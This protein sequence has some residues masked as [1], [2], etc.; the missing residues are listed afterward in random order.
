M[1]SSN[2]TTG[3]NSPTESSAP[4]LFVHTTQVNKPDINADVKEG[5]EREPPRWTYRGQLKANRRREAAQ[6][7]EPPTPAKDALEQAKMQILG[8]KRD[9]DSIKDRHTGS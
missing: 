9:M 7:P 3:T 5:L 2:S 8:F 6:P 4:R 1:S